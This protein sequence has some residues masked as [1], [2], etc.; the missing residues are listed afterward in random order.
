MERELG[1]AVE[2]VTVKQIL[3]E[4]FSLV[5]ERELSSPA[6]PIGAVTNA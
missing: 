3:V 4:Q 5:F 6:V 1:T 2:M